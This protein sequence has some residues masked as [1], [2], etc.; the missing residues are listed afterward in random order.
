MVSAAE[1][2]VVVE[3]CIEPEVRRE[4]T[5]Q[6]AYFMTEEESVR[7]G[8]LLYNSDGSINA[9]FVGISAKR[10]ASRAGFSVDGQV[11]LLI[12]EGKYAL[13]DNPYNKEKLCPVLAYYIEDDWQNACEKCI[14][15]LFAKN[16]GHNG[17]LCDPAVCTQKAG[18]EGVGQYS[19]VA[20]QYGRDYGSVPGDDAWKRR[21]RT[22]YH[23]G[24]CIA[25]E[26]CVYPH[27]R[28][29]YPGQRIYQ[30]ILR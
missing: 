25:A 22:G 19:G 23:V 12:A 16:G 4:L 30:E 6:G 14:E 5:A 8:R 11:E 15:L 9:E 20:W 29:R 7:L 3:R 26:S 2:S 28:G 10:L 27:G 17:R 21:D 24:E 18:G 13:S 1:Q